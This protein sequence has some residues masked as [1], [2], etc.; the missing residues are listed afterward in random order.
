MKSRL[1]APT[2][3]LAISVVTAWGLSFIAIEIALREVS[4]GQ[5][6]TLRFLPVLAIYSAMIAPRLLR[7]QVKISLGDLFR[8]SFIGFFTV[9]VYNYSLNTGQTYIPASI[10]ALVIVLNPATIAIIAALWLK[11]IP[12]MRTWAGLV[13][14]LAG[15]VFIVM[16]RHGAP[17]IRKEYLT[18]I[19]IT[20][21]APLSW[22]IFTA[23]LRS[24][25]PRIGA[26]NATTIATIIGS[27]PLIFTID[28]ELIEVVRNANPWTIGSILFLALGCT[29]YGFLAWGVVVKR[30][31]AARAG[32]FIYL[33]PMVAVTASHLML[34]E[35]LDL[36]LLA[37][38]VLVLSGV[39]VATGRIQPEKLFKR[40]S[41]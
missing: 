19:A 6:V 13:V 21:L 5:L 11:E 4:P 40:H 39:A 24:L 12:P 14:A 9:L 23:G 41:K 29:V 34:H 3:L 22:G 17:E 26:L 18:G 30:I 36:P 7:G 10:A 32:A 15:V 38:A 8:L 16:A 27:F 37:G 31:E 25:T 1:D 20:L 28:T 2:A 35:P 33:N